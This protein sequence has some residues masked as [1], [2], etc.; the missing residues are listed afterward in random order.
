M[1][2]ICEKRL[3]LVINRFVDTSLHVNDIKCSADGSLLQENLCEISELC[4]R[5]TL[6]QHGHDI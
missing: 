1:E 5:Q 2:S 3:N 4:T 6:S